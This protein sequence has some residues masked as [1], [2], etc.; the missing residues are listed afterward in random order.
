M[1]V[2]LFVRDECERSV[3]NQASKV[4]SVDFATSLWEA[5]HEKATCRAY[6]R[7]LK[8]HAKLSISWVSR[9]KGQPVK[10]PQNILFGKKLC[11]FTKFFTHTIYTLITDEL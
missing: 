8:S 2:G 9:E 5:I 3:K 11:C 4:E 6:D 1:Y 10:Y 7:K